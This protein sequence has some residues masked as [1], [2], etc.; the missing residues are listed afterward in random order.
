MGEKAKTSWNNILKKPL[1]VHLA[2]FL[3]PFFALGFAFLVVGLFPFG[4][5][6]SLTLD[7][8]SQYITF[9]AYFKDQVLFG[10]GNFFYTFSKALGGEMAGFAAYYLLSPFN[11]L[12]VFFPTHLLPLGASFVILLKVGFCGLSFSLLLWDEN[13]SAKSILFSVPYALMD[14]VVAFHFNLMWLDGVALLPLVVLGIRRLWRGKSPLL[15]VLSLAAAIVTN[16]YIGYM[17]CIFSLVY[18]AVHALFFA[19]GLGGGRGVLRFFAASL[20]CGGLSCVVLLP[21]IFSLVG[22]K[23]GFATQNFWDKSFAG[24]AD[25]T[26]RYLPG[27]ASP[28]QVFFGYPAIYCGM[29]CLLCAILFFKNRQV[30]KPMRIGGGVLLL[31]LL[32]SFTTGWADKI[33]H[34]FNKP[35]GFLYRYSFMLSFVLLFLAW[36]GFCKMHKGLVAKA[37]PPAFFAGVVVFLLAYRD[38][39]THITR[40]KVLAG[41]LFAL[42]FFALLWLYGRQKFKYSA[43][44]MLFLMLIDMG[45]NLYVSLRH[46]GF[47]P[48]Q[49]Y[50]SFVLQQKPVVD[51]VK[52]QDTGFYRMEKDFAYSDNDAF[53]L[54]Y[55]GLSHFSS[56]DKMF[57]RSFL[58]DMGLSNGGYG[59]KYADGTTVAMESLLGLKYL[60]TTAAGTP[61]PYGQIYGEKERFVWQNPLALPLGF[62]VGDA[63]AQPMPTEK[64][65][66]ERFNSIWQAVDPAFT[67]RLYQNLPCETVPHNV[68]LRQFEGETL[69]EKQAEDSRVEF[70]VTAPSANM[71]YAYFTTKSP[72]NVGLYINGSFDGRFLFNDHHGILPLGRFNAGDKVTVALAPL[73]Y[74]LFV[75][76]VFFA[77]EDGPALE[78]SVTRLKKGAWQALVQS[79]SHI[80]GQVQNPA[81]KQALLFF[82]IPYEKGW[83]ATVNGKKT[84]LQ[85]AF[86]ALMALPIPPGQSK[87]VLQYTP[88]GFWPGALISTSSLLVLIFWVKRGAKHAYKTN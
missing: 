32:L 88:P 23:A 10:N 77:S 3:L 29:L 14:F 17:L 79:P 35:V 72:R 85:P 59:V 76:D 30:A 13:P 28:A 5:N 43:V 81:Q 50:T 67:G 47:L 46:A 20:L 54:G 37:L 49:E 16:Y 78:E 18:F 68:N 53:L 62:A 21:A 65:P 56:A 31:V 69:Y 60:V 45:F 15:Y 42:G 84:A 61:K 71:L 64:N 55:N 22:G 80:G 66:F 44:L 7:L 26:L 58:D 52:S 2:A 27:T 24:L 25:V 36:Q 73:D 19:P 63:A 70:T 86:G 82:S 87:V 40:G 12:L 4:A 75:E 83:Q 8:K 6:S 41:L 48:M 74:E 39:Y 34:G 51:Y 33:W 1:A 11:F 9:F 57:V 38:S